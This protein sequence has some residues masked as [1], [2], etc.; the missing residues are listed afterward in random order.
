ME[1]KSISHNSPLKISLK[2]ATQATELIREIIIPWR[3]EYAKSMAKLSEVEKQSDIESKKADILSKRVNAVKEKAEAEKI[4][5]ET[6][7]QRQ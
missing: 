5:A 1:I 4:K 3:R 6:E 2:G 7:L